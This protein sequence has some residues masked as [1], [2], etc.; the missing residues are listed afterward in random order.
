MASCESLFCEEIRV[1]LGIQYSAFC[2]NKAKLS[3]S[4]W[5]A[6]VL[7]PKQSECLKLA[8][9]RND[10]I[11]CLPTGY[12]KSLLY[13]VLPY[14]E[15]VFRQ[16]D[17]VVVVV[18]PLNAIIDD[19][20]RNIG[21][22]AVKIELGK[23]PHAADLEDVKCRYILGH[24]EAILDEKMHRILLSIAKRV[25]WIVVDEAHCIV[26]WGPSF[27]PAYEQL[28]RLRA[29]FP[30]A[31]IMALTATASL[32]TRA[33]IS[34][35]LALHVSFKIMSTNRKNLTLVV[36]DILWICYLFSAI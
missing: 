30:D 10:I 18:M 2:A 12:G 34:C 32:R 4:D 20:M 23:Q 24:P 36:F 9:N 17:T 7:K 13:E 29:L 33:E 5:K 14:V 28:D 26:K 31:K 27:R 35:S 25:S 16:S 15:D 19:H 11:A 8:A 3:K 22:R 6:V 21:D 1:L